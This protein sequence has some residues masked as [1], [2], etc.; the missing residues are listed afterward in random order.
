MN[1]NSKY[2]F[3]LLLI[4]LIWA[5]LFSISLNAEEASTSQDRKILIIHSYHQGL[6]W[7]DGQDEGIR[8]ILAAQ[9]N[10]EICSEYLDSKRI[11]PEKIL[12]YFA[13]FLTQKYA[14]AGF[15]AIMATDNNALTFL[16]KS[17][18]GDFAYLDV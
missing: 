6:L 7:T 14:T 8:K 4:L 12:D 5:F 18:F 3:A 15:D 11:A 17:S 13:E 1:K 16:S 9:P 2:K 10:I